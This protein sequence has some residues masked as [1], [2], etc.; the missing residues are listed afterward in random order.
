MMDR[1]ATRLTPYFHI[2]ATNDVLARYAIA[3]ARRVIK[4]SHPR[5]QPNRRRDA[6]APNSLAIY[7]AHVGGGV[8]LKSIARCV[9]CSPQW[10]RSVVQR[11]EN[12]R[13]NDSAERAGFDAWL[14]ARE[15]EAFQ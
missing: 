7:L 9:G 14:E 1:M 11:V 13:D 8:P 15:V 10:A 3:A 6:F 12:Y 2:G 5:R 4:Q